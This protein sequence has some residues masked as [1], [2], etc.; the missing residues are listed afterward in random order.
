MFESKHTKKLT[1]VALALGLGVASSAQAILITSESDAMVLANALLSGGGSGIDLMSVTA[2]LS[3]HQLAT[4]AGGSSGTYTNAS[5]TYGIGPGIV[6][7]S[8]NVLDY[9]DGT[10]DNPDNT[11][12]YGVNATV[13]QEALLDPITGGGLDHEDVTQLDISFDMLPGAT[14]EIFFNVT[15]GSEEYAEFVGTSFIDAFGLYVNGTNIASVSGAPVNINH[16]DMAFIGG[17]ELDGI[18]SGSQGVFGPNVHTFNSVVNPTGNTL[19]FIIA[20]SG[21]D[22]LDSTA[23]ISQLGGTPPPPPTIVPEP[24]TLTLMLAG[25]LGFGA[26]RRVFKR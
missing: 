14:P 10:N 15:F 4:T 11:T 1:G 5:N 9:E 25:L 20:D 24:T 19:T 18:L 12:G 23:Y 22:A 21:D 13:A 6:I 16:P 26:R 17:T 7:S 3:G 2:T 8:G